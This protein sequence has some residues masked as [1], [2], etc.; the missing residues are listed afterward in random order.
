MAQF[1][2]TINCPHCGDHVKAVCPDID[3]IPIKVKADVQYFYFQGADTHNEITC[4]ECG[5]SITVY[6]YY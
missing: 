2:A 3:K 6:W 1:E 5:N 4:R